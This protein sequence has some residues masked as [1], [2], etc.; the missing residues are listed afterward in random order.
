MPGR[1]ISRKKCGTWSA[2]H[3]DIVFLLLADFPLPLPVRVPLLIVKVIAQLRTKRLN[4]RLSSA[5]LKA[6]PYL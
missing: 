5:A 3:D 4:Q 1:L 6:R 2:K